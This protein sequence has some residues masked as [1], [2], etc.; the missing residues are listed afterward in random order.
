MEVQLIEFVGA[1]SDNLIG[2][3]YDTLNCIYNPIPGSMFVPTATTRVSYH[4]TTPE[5][6]DEIKIRLPLSLNRNHFL[7]F[8]V[9]HVRVKASDHRNSTIGGIFGGGRKSDDSGEVCAM[10]GQGFMPLLSQSSCLVSDGDY[11]VPIMERGEEYVPAAGHLS[12]SS[13]DSCVSTEASST[14]ARPASS[15]ISGRRTSSAPVKY[16]PPAVI[17]RTRAFSSFVSKDEGLQSFII[18][19]PPALGRLPSL[20][21]RS[22]SE[23]STSPVG[24]LRDLNHFSSM[25]SMGSMTDPSCHKTAEELMFDA[26][27]FFVKLSVQVGAKKGESAE[28]DAHMRRS[29]RFDDTLKIELAGHFLVS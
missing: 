28:E 14:S 10:I 19:H 4:K 1:E 5:F 22:G 13:M 20:T 26:T 2:R 27:M 17:V 12:V 16:L 6:N 15:T 3:E 8:K 24:P 9:F 25:Q 7:L 21:T 29:H 18:N 23:F 11:V